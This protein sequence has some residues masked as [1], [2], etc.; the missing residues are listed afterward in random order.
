[1]IKLKQLLEEKEKVLYKVNYKDGTSDY[2]EMTHN[3]R[4]TM[5][6]GNVESV[7]GMKNLSLPKGE[8]LISYENMKKK[9][10]KKR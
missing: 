10:K 6:Y 3:E 2:V 4:M 8:K 7:G 1:M 9:A 5:P